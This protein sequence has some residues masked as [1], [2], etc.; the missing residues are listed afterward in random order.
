MIVELFV[1][2]VLANAPVTVRYEVDS[3]DACIA[4]AHE[5]Q[6]LDNRVKYI[7]YVE[8]LSHSPGYYA[9]LH[10]DGEVLQADNEQGQKPNR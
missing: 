6:K 8:C 5:L 4:K 1:V 2:Y 3:M 7:D 9:T 10:M